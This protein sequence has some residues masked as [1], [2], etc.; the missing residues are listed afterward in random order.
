MRVEELELQQEYVKV[1]GGCGKCGW[2]RE[3]SELLD[4]SNKIQSK[5]K[6]LKEKVREEFAEHNLQEHGGEAELNYLT[7]LV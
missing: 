6:S 2:F 1:I 3:R 5:I 4:S 7:P